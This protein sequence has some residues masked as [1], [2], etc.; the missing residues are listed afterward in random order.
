[1]EKK[2]GR[3]KVKIFK[4][5]YIVLFIMNIFAQLYNFIYNTFLKCSCGVLS[6]EIVCKN[7]LCYSDSYRNVIIIIMEF[8]EKYYYITLVA[9]IILSI[10]MLVLSIKKHK[11]KYVILSIIGILFPFI[12]VI[13]TIILSIFIKNI[14]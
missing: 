2:I 12:S 3:N 9:M 7:K 8:I 4:I 11:T 6:G 5:F 14:F 13:I 1:M 10:I